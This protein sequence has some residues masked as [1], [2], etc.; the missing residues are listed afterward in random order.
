MTRKDQLDFI[1]GIAPAAQASQAKWSV[2]ASVTLAQAILE[3][4]WGESALTTSARNYFGIKAR[5]ID[6]YVELKTDEFIGGT[7]KAVRAGFRKF[8]SDAECFDAHGELLGTLA[9]YRPAMAKADDPVI[10]AV[11]LQ[12]CGYSTDPDYATKLARLIQ[13]FDLT[14]YDV[15]PP[16][17]LKAAAAGGAGK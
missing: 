6:P 2:P 14:Q 13:D 7:R 3:S 8:V 12:E 4:G 16:A 11:K 1:T 17:P 9:R 15:P 5:R 10:F